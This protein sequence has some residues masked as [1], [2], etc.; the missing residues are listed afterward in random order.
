MAP[1]SLRDIGII[2]GGFTSSEAPAQAA[3]VSDSIVIMIAEKKLYAIIFMRS[4]IQSISISIFEA[5]PLVK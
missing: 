2:A 3:S 1:D 4:I 5:Q